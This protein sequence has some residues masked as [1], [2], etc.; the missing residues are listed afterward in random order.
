[1]FFV[2][3]AAQKQL[4]THLMKCKISLCKFQLLM[5]KE[6]NFSKLLYLEQVFIL[7]IIKLATEH[8]RNEHEIN[9]CFCVFYRK[10]N[11]TSSFYI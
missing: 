2:L 4:S 9:D 10:I 6:D 8:Y 11:A 7:G 3:A 1:M 5:C